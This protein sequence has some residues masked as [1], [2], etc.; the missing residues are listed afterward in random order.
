MKRYIK[1]N[2]EPRTEEYEGYFIDQYLYPDG[3][4]EYIV[5][6]D[7][8]GEGDEH[9]FGSYSEAQDFIDDLNRIEDTKHR[10]GIS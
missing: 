1:A 8:T 6:I 10:L 9:S 3:S 5:D 4:E 7:I 2:I